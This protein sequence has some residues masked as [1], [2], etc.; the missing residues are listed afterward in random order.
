MPPNFTN[1][2]ILVTGGTG[3][4][5]THV[6]RKLKKRG[7]PEKNISVPRSAEVDLREVENC[8]HTVRGVDIVIHLAG[9]TGGPEF[10]KQH[11]AE[12]F[13]DNM[14]MGAELVEAARQA[15]VEKFVTIGSA[16][17]YP[18]NAPLPYRE[19]D[20]WLGPPEKSHVSYTTAKRMLLAQGQAYRM[21]Y[22][23]NL[24]HLWPT[25]LSGPG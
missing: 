21:L 11:P 10:H 12:I 18:D 6:V 24:I 8:R 2:K 3:F 7:V 13:Y 14:I 15:R 4:L 1:K 25:N 9:V 19:E 23:M 5:G 17:E 20:I 22:G 16:T